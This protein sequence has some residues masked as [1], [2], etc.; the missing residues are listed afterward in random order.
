MVTAKQKI[1]IAGVGGAGAG[2]SLSTLFAEFTSRASGQ[3]GWASCAVKGVVK[4]V[5][6]LLSYGIGTRL[7]GLGTMFFEIFSYTSFGSILMDV[8]VAAY[9]GGI[10]GLAEDWA[11]TARVFAAGGRGTAGE[12]AMLERGTEITDVTGK[13]VTSIL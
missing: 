8:I 4:I 13:K 9:P 11:V 6:G 3:V 12:L 10:P 2:A 5:V 7:N 1:V